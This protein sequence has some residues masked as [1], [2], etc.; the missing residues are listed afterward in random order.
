MCKKYTVQGSVLERYAEHETGRK[1]QND[2][3]LAESRLMGDTDRG[4]IGE[5]WRRWPTQPIRSIFRTRCGA[6]G[7]RPPEW[8]HWWRIPPIAPSIVPWLSGLGF[9]VSVRI[10]WENRWWLRLSW[11][12]LLWLM[13]RNVSVSQSL[14]NTSKWPVTFTVANS[15]KFWQRAYF[16]SLQNS[17][18]LWNLFLI[19]Q[20]TE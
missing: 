13:R 14:G 10:D 20:K 5:A 11:R 2:I 17:T 3:R 18:I 9:F 4:T 1:H 15:V 8:V 19:F 7:R 16:L 12:F 6:S